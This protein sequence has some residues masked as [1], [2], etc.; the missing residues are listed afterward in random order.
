MRFHRL[1]K[2]ASL[3][4]SIKTIVV[5]VL[6]MT[7]LGLGLG[8]VR[9]MFG[10]INR[11]SEGTFNQ[12]EDQL[13][14]ALTDGNQKLA[15][16]QSKMAVERGKTTFLGWGIRNE[17]SAKLNY[18]VEFKPIKCPTACPTPNEINNGWFTFKYA[19]NGVPQYSVDAAS[20]KVERVDLNIPKTVGVD[21]GLYLIEMSVYDGQG[22]A[23][24][25]DSI[26]LFIT[27]T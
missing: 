4:M 17:G 14:K 5:I 15:F 20:Q 1:N 9:N 8:F 12:I 21:T 16:S 25:Y 13:Q 10:N 23:N 11:L 18:W 27:V 24:K 7:L 26:D 19:S 3:E 22:T 6:A 2:K